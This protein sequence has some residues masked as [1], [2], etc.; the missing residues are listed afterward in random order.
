MKIKSLVILLI[1]CL[2]PGILA[3]EFKADSDVNIPADRIIDDDF[4]VAGGKVLV[5]GAVEGDLVV[6]G[7]NIELK[8]IVEQDLIV[9]GGDIQ[10]S[11]MI[12]D[13]ARIAGGNIQMD[14]GFAAGTG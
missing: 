4:Y 6:A 12:S 10:I 2:L 13:D 5:E 14:G 7:G 11:G 8:G 9:A 1:L 3:L